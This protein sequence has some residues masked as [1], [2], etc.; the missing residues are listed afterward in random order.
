M[1]RQKKEDAKQMTIREAIL[2]ARNELQEARGEKGLDCRD[3]LRKAMKLALQGCQLSR[4]EVAERM[5]E[6]T[7]LDITGV[8]IDA[9]LADSKRERHLPAELLPAFCVACGDHGPIEVLCLGAGLFAMVPAD[10]L[11]T[12]LYRLRQE[13]AKMLKQIRQKETFL[14]RIEHA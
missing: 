7:G 5:S 1:A 6:L 4:E 2:K 12:D 10:A 3:E 13:H 14:R 9:W 11:R 8:Q